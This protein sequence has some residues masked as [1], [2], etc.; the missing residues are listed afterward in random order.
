M[1][2][3]PGG[4]PDN[5]FVVIAVIACR[6]AYR[7]PC[8][9]QRNANLHWSSRHRH[10]AATTTKTRTLTARR[11]NRLPKLRSLFIPTL[12]MAGIPFNASIQGR[13]G[14]G[15]VKFARQVRRPLVLEGEVG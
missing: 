12:R 2:R 15:E 10:P 1:I 9:R 3:K 6:V 7:V 4:R 13:A 14:M 5:T 8:R 11:G